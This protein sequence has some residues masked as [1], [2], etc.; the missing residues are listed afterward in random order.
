MIV[1]KIELNLPYAIRISQASV[2]FALDRLWTIG[3]AFIERIENIMANMDGIEKRI[4][5]SLQI[6]V[7]SIVFTAK[8][9]K[10]DILKG[11]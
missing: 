11:W 9:I 8:N 3:N 7:H 6:C 2:L 10:T 5:A 4:I 1:L